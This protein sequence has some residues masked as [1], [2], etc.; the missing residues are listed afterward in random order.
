LVLN[1]MPP[2]PFFTLFL[3]FL[4]F[5]SP[6]FLPQIMESLGGDQKWFDRFIA[7]H[8]AVVYYWVLIIFYLASPRLAY[9]FS[10]LVEL[11]ATDTYAEFVEQNAEA[12]AQLPPPQVAAAYYR[13]EDLY[14]V[15]R[16]GGGREWA[17]WEGGGGSGRCGGGGG[18]V[19]GRG[20][21]FAGS[22]APGA[23]PT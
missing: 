10:E 5:P 17:V 2:A 6:P 8:A 23:V 15:R 16:G 13:N 18:K 19:E 4:A 22:R 21:G 9:M 7:E 14:M 12:L 11:H 20:G 1:H 3:L